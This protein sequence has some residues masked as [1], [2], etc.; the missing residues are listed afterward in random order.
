MTVGVLLSIFDQIV[1]DDFQQVLVSFCVTALNS[2]FLQLG[3]KIEQP[4][5]EDQGWGLLG[6]F[7]DESAVLKQDQSLFISFDLLDEVYSVIH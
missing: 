6:G 1:S 3:A 7:V 4:L 5:G 2:C